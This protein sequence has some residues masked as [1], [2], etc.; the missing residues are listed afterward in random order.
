MLAIFFTFFLRL[1]SYTPRF[2]RPAARGRRAL[3]QLQIFKFVQCTASDCAP[4]L[5]NK[6]LEIVIEFEP[7]DSFQLTFGASLW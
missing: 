1:F 5:L 6:K 7:F 2:P 3:R 4:S